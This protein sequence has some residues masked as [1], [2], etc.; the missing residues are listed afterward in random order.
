MAHWS[1]GPTDVSPGAALGFEFFAAIAG[2]GFDVMIGA[3][4]FAAATT[5]FATG[6]G[7][8]GFRIDFSGFSV[9]GLAVETGVDREAGVL[10]FAD[11]W[12]DTGG[13]IG[14][15]LFFADRFVP[16]ALDEPRAL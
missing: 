12:A 7:F 11:R 1:D 4:G 2:F 5:G 9:G 3:G 14:A 15:V 13:T 8:V 16:L 6:R 10:S